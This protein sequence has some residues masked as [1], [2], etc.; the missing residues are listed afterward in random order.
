MSLF[1]RQVIVRLGPAGGTGRE[2]SGLRVG[3]AVKLSTSSS[4]NTA[5]I[6][7][8]NPAPDTISAIQ[9]P[10]AAIELLAGYSVARLRFRGNPTPG[11]VSIARQGPDRIL[12]IEAQEAGYAWRSARVSVSYAES[13]DLETVYAEVSTQLGLPAAVVQ[14]PSGVVFA[15]GLVLTGLA[16]DVLAR[17]AAMSGSQTFTRDG[18]I[19]FIPIDGD[20]GEV[21]PIYSAASGNLIGS[22]TPTVASSGGSTGGSN[23]I[24]IRGLLDAD[25]RPGQK[26]Q[27]ESESYNGT[28]TATDVSM[29]GDSGFAQDFYLDATGT[30]S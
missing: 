1:G 19:C 13:V 30:A 26:F 8:Y 5:T 22:P 3:F 17:L 7:I 12:K 24:K 27:V 6:T 16:S 25:L 2:L 4:V 18:G 21:A 29:S 10:T 9:D 20:T 28:Y 23:G 11:G 15:P 14:V